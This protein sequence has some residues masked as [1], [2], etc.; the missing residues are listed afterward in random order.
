[1]TVTSSVLERHGAVG[2]TRSRTALVV[3]ANGAVRADWARYYEAFGIRTLRCVGPQVMCPLVAGDP[4]CHLYDDAD[5]VVYDQLTVTPELTL[6]LVR[7]KR[8]LPIA[9]AT[10]R[11]DHD[12]HHTPQITS[13]ASA[14]HDSG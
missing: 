10:D 3:S 2:R 8:S 1:M 12:G 9:F 14:T 5:F 13:L 4:H 6:K 11:I 7:P